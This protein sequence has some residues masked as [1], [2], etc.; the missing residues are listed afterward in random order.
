MRAPV[1]LPVPMG[2]ILQALVF[3]SAAA[4]LAAAG[5][6]ALTLAFVAVAVANAALMGAWRQ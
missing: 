5:H 1:P 4:G 6:R 3:G 2:L